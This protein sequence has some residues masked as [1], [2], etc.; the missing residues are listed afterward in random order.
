MQT[1]P[2][3]PPL[4]TALER[5]TR[6]EVLRM[7]GI[8]P[9]QMARWERLR[10]VEPRASEAEARVYSFEDLVGLRTI[11]QAA[12]EGVPASRLGAA[13]EAIRRQA[14]GARVSLAHLRIVPGRS[15]A[16]SLAG[17]RKAPAELTEP[18][19]PSEPIRPSQR[20]GAGGTRVASASGRSASG[21]TGAARLALEYDGKM[22]EPLS[23]QL[24]FRFEP[25]ASN[26]RMMKER[27]VEDWLAVAAQSEGDAARRPQAIEAYLRVV[28]A[29]P[30]LVEAHIN[31][32]TLFYEQG[33][34]EDARDRFQ[35]AVTLGPENA[36]A[37]FNLGSVLD[38]L[39]E[40]SEASEHLEEAVRLKPDYADAHYNLARV[41]EELGAFIEARPH[42]HRY[43]DLDPDSSWAEYAR[44]R[45][46]AS[47]SQPEAA[48]KQ[49]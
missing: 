1:R 13:V 37:H 28:E 43:L 45:L 41:Y 19:G 47:S 34:L 46:A 9:R 32:G 40:F 42:W 31:L 21:R 24:V 38:E 17:A 44:Q 36:L 10:L 29:A 14:G 4:R 12:R 26:L 2:T 6:A 11:K 30:H 8:T 3:E 25:A 35:I 23:G 7:A 5:F 15:S 18:I 49:E 22:I 48:G 33:E 16:V 27:T 39:K 20:D